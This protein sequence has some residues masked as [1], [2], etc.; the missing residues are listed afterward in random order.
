V[1]GAVMAVGLALA[2]DYLDPSFRTPS[3]VLTE[4]NIPVLA[5]VPHHYSSGGYGETSGLGGNGNG[6]H[7][8][9]EPLQAYAVPVEAGKK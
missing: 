8:T 4:L 5:A 2:L 1:M 7:A 9:V 6:H 3:D